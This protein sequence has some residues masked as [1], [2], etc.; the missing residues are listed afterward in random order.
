[1][2][3]APT[4]PVRGYSFT[5]FSAS[6]PTA[7]QPGNRLDIEIDRSNTAIAAVI[8]FAKT[9]LADDGTLKPDTVG[10][11][12]LVS[13][14]LNDVGQASADD[15]AA[16][17]LQAAG[18]AG[19]AFDLKQDV[20]VIKGD[21][22]ALQAVIAG[23]AADVGADILEAQA[24]LSTTAG[25]RADT[26]AARDLT[27]TYRDSAA[28]HSADALA[29]KNIAAR[30][31]S[32]TSGEIEP[33]LYSA[34]YYAIAA[35]WTPGGAIPGTAA[36][37]SFTPAGNI[38][39]SNVQTALQELDNE[40]AGL[41]HT[42]SFTS[43]TGVLADAQIPV[44][45]TA[46]IPG[47][48]ASKI[49]SG[50]FDSARLP[51][52]PT[53]T[54]LVAAGSTIA[55][56]TGP[57]QAA[58]AQGTYVYLSNGQRW[59]Y[60]GSGG[61]TLE[62]SYVFIGDATPDWTEVQNK[63]ATFAPAAH[64]HPFTDLTGVADA[65]QIPSLDAA[66]T[67]S[68]TFALARIP[69]GLQAKLDANSVTGAMLARG[70]TAGH[71]WTANGSG[72]DA[73]FQ[74][75]ATPTATLP[76]GYI[77]GFQIANVADFNVA[78]DVTVSPGA[79]RDSANA[80]NL[81]TTATIRKTILS[82]FAEYVTPGTATGG[83][84]PADRAWVDGFGTNWLHVHMIGGTGKNPQ[85]YLSTSVAPS[86]PSGF[87]TRR[88][89]GS[90]WVVAGAIIAFNQLGDEFLW[91][92]PVYA[93]NS[94][95]AAGPRSLIAVAPPGVVTRAMCV[96]GGWNNGYGITLSSPDEY[97]VT[98]AASS[99]PLTGSRSLSHLHN[100][101]STAFGATHLPVRTDSSGQVGL[102]VS[103]G[104]RSIFLLVRGWLD[105]RGKDA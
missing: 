23:D 44:L 62:A 47:M 54:K 53:I 41:S 59:V 61:K 29:N 55:S 89:I 3:A 40:K 6:Q 1:M 19:E 72:A 69:T 49:T 79:A 11:D 102:R 60:Q 20:L 73:S 75:P 7:Q 16:S 38:A 25:Y 22:Q 58:V 12:Q 94:T 30:W 92:S 24:L 35:G 48:D 77:D 15:A 9:S 5:D 39:A 85:P 17:A 2:A 98:P 33:G 83:L 101:G 13:G 27:L 103:D 95:R 104:T 36:G 46:K 105:P 65:A 88:R 21:I 4:N 68:G 80:A 84:D 14:L 76:R 81:E 34:R 18:S 50:T 97:D 31:A 42:H 10:E 51:S 56:L 66:K 90:I 86:L 57:E 91:R 74:A 78:F 64:T 37:T 96:L 43:I 67:N 93:F 8:A 32:D 45:S 52:A 70:G 87:T 71:V 26:L 82:N 28:G 99:N 100:S 63:P